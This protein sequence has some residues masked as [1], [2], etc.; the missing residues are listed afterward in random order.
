MPKTIPPIPQVRTAACDAAPAG[1]RA[2]PPAAAPV[3]R[4]APPLGLSD[5][6]VAAR[7]LAAE[8]PVDTSRVA[9]LKARIADGSYRPDPQAI[10][11]KMIAL[12]LPRER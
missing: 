12:D 1:I 11:T 3:A 9:D 10:A 6:A 5:T 4:A 2:T 8:P 7:A